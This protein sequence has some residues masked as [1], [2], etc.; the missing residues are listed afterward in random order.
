[1]R[2]RLSIK[3]VVSITAYI[4]IL[5]ITIILAGY[6][7]VSYRSALFEDTRHTMTDVASSLSKNLDDKLRDLSLSVRT[8]A[9]DEDTARMLAEGDREGLLKKYLPLFKDIK[10][11]YGIAQF[12]FHTPPAISFLRLH[13]PDKFGDDLSSFRQ[14]VVDANKQQKPMIGLEVGRGGPG[15]RAVFPVFYEGKLYG[16]VEYGGSIDS[17]LESVKDTFDMDYV[18]GIKDSVFKQAKRFETKDTDIVKDGVVFYKYTNEHSRDLMS[19]YAP[20]ETIVYDGHKILSKSVE[21]KDFQGEPIGEVILFKDISDKLAA[22]FNYALKKLIVGFVMASGFAVFLYYFMQ[23]YLKLLVTMTRIIEAVTKG[24]G[25][26][27][28]RIPVNREGNE[29]E[30]VSFKMN[31]FLDTM[32]KNI[33]RTTYSLGNLLGKIMPIYYALTEVRKSSNENVDLAA[34]VAAAGEEMSITV[35]EISRN[36]ADV[37]AKG[38]QTLSLATEGSDLVREAAEKAENVK[39]VVDSLASDINS[40][41]EN[42]QSIGSVVEVINDISEQTNLLALNAAIEAARAGE[43]GRGFAVVADEVRKLAE[44]TLASTNEI[45]K[46]VKIIQE[47]VTRADRNAAEVSESISSQVKTSEEANSRFQDILSSVEELNGLLLNI[48]TASE[49]QAGATAE[50]ANSIEKVAAASGTSRDNVMGLMGQIYGLMDDLATLEKD[51]IQYELSCKGIVFVKAKM[52]HV[53]YLKNLFTAFMTGNRPQGLKSDHEC[54]FGQIYFSKDIQEL[55]KNDADFK[56]IEAP[57]KEVHQLSHHI[58]DMIAKGNMDA[59]YEDLMKMHS[60]VEQLI[61]YLEIMF[62][63]AK[64]I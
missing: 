35:E 3:Q 59:A 58:S 31:D 60:R 6:D 4:G 61:K 54:D 38:E 5:F 28:K 12:Q 18:I 19:Q 36:T 53:K 16:S 9:K 29:L 63:K 8:V 27:S 48:S 21:L 64:C 2:L 57:H 33:S 52:A 11:D 10:D 22:S 40:L 49:Q 39:S 26:L 1:M 51:L 7:Y 23:Y 14:T 20:E 42:A 45:E 62:D 25:D 13:K 24:H 32:D 41:T 47:N 30:S 50:V 44:K 17:S 55:Y 34:T 15:L 46:M 56:A 37:A 43:A